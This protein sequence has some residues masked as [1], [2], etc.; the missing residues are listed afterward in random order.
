MTIRLLARGPRPLGQFP[1]CPRLEEA[2]VGVLAGLV[3]VR[4]GELS[5]G[6]ARDTQEGEW[7]RTGECDSG[8]HHVA[9][10]VRVFFHDMV[11]HER[12]AEQM[13]RNGHSFVAAP[14]G[15]RMSDLHSPVVELM[16]RIVRAADEGSR[17]FGVFLLHRLG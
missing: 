14:V 12:R 11:L 17:G 9:D 4:N 13:Q 7:I 5:Q 2:R 6:D 1:E 16:E 8:A 3:R 10:Q 15:K